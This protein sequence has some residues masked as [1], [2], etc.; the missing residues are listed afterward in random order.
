MHPQDAQ[1][2]LDIIRRLQDRSID[3]YVD[4][5]FAR[6]YV[7]T[8]ALAVFIAFS[9]ADLP[10]PWDGAVSTFAIVLALTVGAV[11]Y[12]QAR[13]RRRRTALEQLYHAAW[14]ILFLVICV[15]FQLAAAL[16][17]VKLG[18]PAHHTIGAAATALTLVAIARPCAAVL[19]ALARNAVA[20]KDR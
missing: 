6:P 11:S 2:S 3:E 17:A 5:G 9:A 1:K 14:V 7:L 13:V 20:V 10:D 8:S 19:K 12:R 15:V 18:I 16:A 4:H